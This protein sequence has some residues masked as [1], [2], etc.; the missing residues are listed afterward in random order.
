LDPAVQVQL[1]A[2]GWIPAPGMPADLAERIAA[3]A[4]MWGAVIDQIQAQQ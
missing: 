4:E 3:D 1:L 2:I